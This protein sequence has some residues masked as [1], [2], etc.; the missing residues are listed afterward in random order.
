[1]KTINLLVN[2]SN[3]ATLSNTE[4]SRTS[5]MNTFLVLIS[6]YQL[7]KL[8]LE[9]VDI[10][11]KTDEKGRMW[12]NNK[13]FE[14]VEIIPGMNILGISIK[15]GNEKKEEKPSVCSGKEKCPGKKVDEILV[16]KGRMYSEEKSGEEI[17]DEIYGEG[18]YGEDFRIE[19]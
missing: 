7:E 17:G 5:Q 6:P 15:S 19:A 4:N 11:I 8:K 18:I 10:E 3:Q 13:L 14:T 2:M 9:G 1:M 12:V 16:C